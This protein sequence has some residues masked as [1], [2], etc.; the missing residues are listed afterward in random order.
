MG[1]A[2][3]RAIRARRRRR[4]AAAVLLVAGA[5][6]G[7]TAGLWLGERTGPPPV[8][9]TTEVPVDSAAALAAV[10]PAAGLSAS[11]AVAVS[12]PE[13]AGATPHPAPG[14]PGSTA[15]GARPAWL[16]NA[17]PVRDD[18]RP[19]IAI[20]LDDMGVA[21]RWS[22]RAV[23][24]P[25]GLTLSYLGYAEDLPAQTA[26][27]RRAG[28]EL[29]VHVAMEPDDP[30][31][32]TGPNALLTTLSVAENLRRLRW[33]LSRFKGY[34]GVNNHMG[35]RF[36]RDAA[37]MGPVIEAI[38]KR[39]LLF[40]DSRTTPGSVGARLA[41]LTG[42]PVAVRDVFIDN[43]TDVEKIIIQLEAAERLA[44]RRGYA[45]AIGHPRPATLTA[46]D[47]WLPGLAERGVALVPI[48]AIV[49]RTTGSDLT[50][51]RRAAGKG[52]ERP[53]EDRR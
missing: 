26:A 20:V 1:R 10:A 19:M 11:L 35:S 5:A 12:P 41:R 2:K 9:A 31:Q 40:L 47:A 16:A 24:L 49:R 25:A 21:R 52:E 15:K 22:A 34:V 8:A 29:M 51:A 36:T 13:T 48:S 50:V 30:T 46:L 39:G 27:A 32:D 7:L 4:L 18:G 37:L 3:G 33:S 38:G 28:H 23:A 42:V 44:R 43:D 6:G 14:E 53:G 17:V 45:V